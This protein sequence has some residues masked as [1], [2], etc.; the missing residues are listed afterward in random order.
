[1]TI[2]PALLTF[3]IANF[4]FGSRKNR[5]RQSKWEN[6]SIDHTVT[7]AQNKILFYYRKTI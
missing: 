6:Y 5:I 2:R 1:M 4:G 3:I 7:Q